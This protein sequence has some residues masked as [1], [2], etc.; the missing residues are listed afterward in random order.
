MV[1][2]FNEITR[3]ACMLGAAIAISLLATSADA[4]NFK[5]LYSFIGTFDNATDGA[6]PAAGLLR[7]SAGNLYGTASQGGD[8]KC[9]GGCGTVFKYSPANKKETTLLIFHGKNGMTPVGNLI[10]DADG[11]LYGTTLG[12]GKNNSSGVVFKLSAKGVETVLHAFC[13]KKNCTDGKAPY[14]GLIADTSGNL[15]G[16]AS[17]GGA[18]GLG[19]V[20]KIAKGGSETVLH[21]FKGNADGATP[22]GGLMMAANG[23]MYGTTSAGG[24]T[25][26]EGPGCGTIYQITTAGKET[27]LYKFCATGSCV[28]G[29]EPWAPP[30]MDKAGNLYGTTRVGGGHGVGVLFK[31]TPAGKESVIYAFAGGNDGSEP[32][33]GVINDSN[34]NFFG[35]TLFG[36]GEDG[37]GTVFKIT[38]KGKENILH[39]FTGGNDG[40]QGKAGLIMDSTGNLYGTAQVGGTESAGVIYKVVRSPAS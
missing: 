7:D 5:V 21:S 6:V 39:K 25:S 17:A 34:G 31:L 27:A 38:K 12:G 19:V 22:M 20:Y 9:G 15:Y 24:S 1:R 14:G 30:V 36:G 32:T 28:F 26:C 40:G 29:Q 18:L 16:T 3:R 10:E 8:I 4:S 37:Y 35:A 2:T 23:K 33:G 11:N 13:A